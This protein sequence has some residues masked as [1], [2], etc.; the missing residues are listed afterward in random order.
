MRR[1]TRPSTTSRAII[2]DVPF[3]LKQFG[4]GDPLPPPGTH[5]QC[6][7][8]K[9]DATIGWHIQISAT[10]AWRIVPTQAAAQSDSTAVDVPGIVADF[11]ALLAE[12]RATG[13][14]A[15]S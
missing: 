12:L 5:E 10:S 13:G 2:E 6:I 8:A 11:N 3:P 1:S 14:I 4:T 15:G 7:A 9:D